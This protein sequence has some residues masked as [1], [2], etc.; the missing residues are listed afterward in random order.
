MARPVN[1][2]T[3]GRPTG[4]RSLRGATPAERSRFIDENGLLRAPNITR[5]VQEP[6]NANLPTIDQLSSLDEAALGNILT[7]FGI[8]EPWPQQRAAAVGYLQRM[9]DYPSGSP[10]FKAE[11]QRLLDFESK[12]GLNRAV[13]RAY[14]EYTLANTD[15]TGLLIRISE[16][17][18][19]TCDTCIRL[20][21]EI[22]TIAY[23]RS[24]GLPGSSSCQGG[25]R[26]KCAL[27]AYD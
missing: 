3:S 12:D 27:V 23:H 21:G 6:F 7:R 17:D 1:S 25:D 16:G 22:G 19:N 5:F 26:C 15:T 14:R 9:T 24:I 13:R 8:V 4:G 18:E 20:G 2:R 11:L 10:Q